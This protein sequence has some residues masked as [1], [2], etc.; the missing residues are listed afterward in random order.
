MSWTNSEAHYK[1]MQEI[2][3]SLQKTKPLVLKGGTALLLAYGLDRF[4]EDLDFDVSDEL[5]AKG[6][7]NLKSQLEAI[8]S[9]TGEFNVIK[10]KL[11]KDT[12]TTTRYMLDYRAK[13]GDID[14]KLKVEV[15]YR[16]PIKSEEINII[17][18]IAVVPIEN[19]A[20]FKLQSVLDSDNNSRTKARDLYDLSFISENHPQ[21]FSNQ[22]LWDLKNLN[23]DKIESRY[24]NSFNEDVLL[25]KKQN[26]IEKDLTD[27]LII[28]KDSVE[29]EF[30]KRGLD[31][32][33]NNIKLAR[34][35]LDTNFQ[36][37]PE[38]LAQKHEELNSKTP[39]VIAGKIELPVLTKT[40]Q[41]DVEVKNQVQQDNGLDR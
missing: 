26:G 7:L 19:I 28:L 15:S 3:K 38:L 40:I 17:N 33:E 21:A 11:R 12:D 36:D 32:V 35:V 5:K 30:L 37:N 8:K 1:L 20:K 4:S 22:N 24:I 41:P 39:D 6:T 16:T 18:Q 9:K 27:V 23:I 31:I 10:V 2:V 13:D 25:Q 29:K 34:K 14:S